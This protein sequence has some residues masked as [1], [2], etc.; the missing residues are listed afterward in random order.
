MMALK[1]GI[2]GDAYVR[3]ATTRAAVQEALALFGQCPEFDVVA[4]NS[5]IVPLTRAGRVD[6]AR[7]MFDGMPERP[8]AT[9]S[10]M[11]SAY[12]CASRCG[13]D[14]ALFS[15]MQPDGVEPNGNVL[16]S[17]LGCCASLGALD[18]GAWVHRYIDRTAMAS[19]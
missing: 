17:V 5:V 18:Q 12:T 8:V 11:V 10:A 15:A 14:L 9:W 7:A 3:N 4:C 16:V 19:P 1:L 13:E 6:E 2:D